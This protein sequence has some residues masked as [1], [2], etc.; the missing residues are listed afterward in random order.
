MNTA[1]VCERVL[2]EVDG[3][4]TAVRIIDQVTLGQHP[5]QIPTPTLIPVFV[6]VAFKGHTVAGPHKI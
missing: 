3:V 5:R 1:V 4:L 2:R 6:L